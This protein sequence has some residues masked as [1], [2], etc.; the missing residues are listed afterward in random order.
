MKRLFYFSFVLISAIS[1]RTFSQFQLQNAFPNLSFYYPVGIYSAGDGI[2]RIFVVEQ[3]GVIKVF[4]NNRNT[5]TS[6][7]FLDIS[8]SVYFNQDECGLLG[9]AFHPNYKSNGY[10]YV[11]YV[12]DNPLRTVIARFQVS[13]SNP[14]SALASSEEILLTIPQPYSIWHKGGQLNFGSDGYLY[15]GMGDGGP[16]DDPD[17]HGQD[18]TILLGKILRI[19]VDQQ[20]DG[21]NYSIPASNP[22]YQNS[23]GYKQEI[24]AYGLRNP[25]RFNFDPVTGYLWCGD[26]GQDSWEEIDLVQGGKNYGWNC[27]EGFHVFNTNCSGGNYTFPVFEYG[28]T[29]G[30]CAIIGGFVYSG[31]RRPELEGKYIYGDYCTG[32]IWQFQL[33]DSSNTLAANAPTQIY[34]F[35]EDMNG[36]LYIG[37]MDNNIYDFVPAIAAPSNLTSSLAENGKVN[38]AWTDNSDNENGFIIQRK[39][40][41]NIFVQAGTVGANITTFTDTV[42]S[43]DNY[44]YRVIA[45]S[46]SAES[47]Y[48]NESSILVT[49]VSPIPIIS[50]LKYNLSQNYPNPFNPSTI[51]NYTVAKTGLVTIKLY[52]IMGSE[53]AILLNEVKKP[54]NYQL[55]FEEKDLS[56]GVYFYRMTSGGFS[57]VKK[58][59]LVK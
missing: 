14:D 9:L 34:S 24:Y 49:S 41:D 11:D 33:S 46:D 40:S 38:L 17:G 27:Y 43:A 30:N 26:V 52:N 56:S 58:L 36:E 42:N 21:L 39:G 55:T 15:I 4:E 18:L 8:D 50:K 13:Q 7:T 31:K 3:S 19:D 32:S 57:S 51:I 44:V 45:F 6:K 1:N 20:S 29:N 47:D 48:S 35:G 10:F 53:I 5:T 54:G 25:W 59:I 23:S 37:G 2:D 16:E 12:A 28:H 22:F